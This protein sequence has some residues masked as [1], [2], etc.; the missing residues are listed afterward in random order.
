MPPPSVTRE[1]YCYP[2]RQL[3]VRSGGRDISFKR[4]F[5]VQSKIDSVCLS[6][7]PFICLSVP[8]SLNDQTNS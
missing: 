2:R 6:G 4:S 7:C 5:R 8:R 1:I 3:I